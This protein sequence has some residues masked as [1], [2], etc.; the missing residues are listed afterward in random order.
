MEVTSTSLVIWFMWCYSLE[1]RSNLIEV[2]YEKMPNSYDE[3]DFNRDVLIH[4]T[5]SRPSS[6]LVGQ[7]FHI[8]RVPEIMQ[9]VQKK[10]FKLEPFQSAQKVQLH[11]YMH[12][13]AGQIYSFNVSINDSCTIHK[14]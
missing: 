5:P 14:L 13:V 2:T 1:L 6:L 12:Q 4:V 7:M 8:T 10:H 9:E 3:L 11:M